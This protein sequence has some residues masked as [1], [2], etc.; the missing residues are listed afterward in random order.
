MGVRSMDG[1]WLVYFESFFLAQVWLPHNFISFEFLLGVNEWKSGD[2]SGKSPGF[3]L[4][5]MAQWQ[6]NKN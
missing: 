6:T 3:L 4:T 1:G 2:S 5:W